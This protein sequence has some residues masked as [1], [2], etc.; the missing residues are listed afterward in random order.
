MEAHKNFSKKSAAKILT[1]VFCDSRG[2]LIDYL[3]KKE[4]ITGNSIFSIIRQRTQK[5]RFVFARLCQ[6]TNGKLP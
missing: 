2:I 6:H 4:S 5:Q 1:S 3:E